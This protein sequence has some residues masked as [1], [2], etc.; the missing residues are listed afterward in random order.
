MIVMFIILIAGFILLVKGA[1]WFVDSSSLIA[2][3]LHIP[4]MVIGLTIVACG[5]SLPETVVSLF[6]SIQGSNEMAISNVTG[7]NLFNLFLIAGICAVI[8]PMK[9]DRITIKRD[10]PISILAMVIIAGFA[11]YKLLFNSESMYLGRIDGVILLILF[12][13]YMYL[14]LRQAK[15]DRKGHVEDAFDEELIHAINLKDNMRAIFGSK[16]K[17]SRLAP[18]FGFTIATVILGAAC[19]AG[20]GELVVYSATHIATAFGLSETLIGLT[21]ASIGTS[22]PEL[23]TSVAA[24]VKGEYDIA[25]G[26]CIGSNIFNA[27]FVLGIAT[28]VSPVSLIAQNITD[29]AI[30]VGGSLICWLI[31]LAAKKIQHGTAIGMVAFYAAYFAYIIIR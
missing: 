29:I 1:D 23:V 30:L 14:M 7:S 11:L 9:L 13:G 16:K 3:R 25:L 5:T 24:T 28:T 2:K 27:L 22:L 20:G 18:S 17:Y 12:I 8:H 21:I 4:S 26:N 19:T 6:S 10:F 15:K 31:A